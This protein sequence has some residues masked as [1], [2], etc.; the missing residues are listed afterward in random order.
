MIRAKKQ[1]GQHFLKSASALSKIIDASDPVADDIIVEIGPG[2]G[3]LTEKL[4][5]FAGKVIAIE[6]DR[7]LIPLLQE[8][9]KKE[10]ENGKLDLI[11][12]DVLDF[13]P[14][15]LSFY[16]EHS[17]KLVANI[18]YYITGAI[19]EKFLSARQQPEQMVL[20]MQKEVAERVVARN[21]KESILSL[22]VKAYGVP[23]IIA[24]V[25]AGA[26]APAPKVD[27]AILLV[28]T[29]SRNFFAS[30][31][32]RLFF[33]VIKQAF[34]QKR[35]TIGKTLAEKY[36]KEILSVLDEAT[37]SRSTRP[38]DLSILDWKKICQLLAKQLKK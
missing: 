1:F 25:P 10:I 9:F 33:E 37:I 15:V 27:S 19:L 29:I 35:K 26:F 17:Y 5:F 11:E 31:D 14:D 8:T 34:G 16:K 30:L 22:S 18:P 28:E 21:K 4:L 24:K 36:G 13:N 12:Q 7:D 32:E 2:L 6:K 3:A 38:E 20:L 23:K